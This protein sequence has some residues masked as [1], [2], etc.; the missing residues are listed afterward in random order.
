MQLRVRWSDDLLVDD[1]LAAE[2]TNRG[3]GSR[4]QNRNRGDY[5]INFEGARPVSRPLV[6]R[7]P[8]LISCRPLF[9]ILRRC[10]RR[11]RRWRGL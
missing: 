10:Y 11:Y 1:S 2:G 8:W 5:L 7:A 6:R 4:K 9:R 3:R